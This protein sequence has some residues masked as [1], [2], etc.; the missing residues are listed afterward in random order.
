MHSGNSGVR[1]GSGTTKVRFSAPLS[2]A[3]DGEEA[4]PDEVGPAGYVGIAGDHP[5]QP[6]RKST[7]SHH[8]GD[9]SLQPV[10][11]F[12]G[13]TENFVDNLRPPVHDRDYVFEVA[14][15]QIVAATAAPE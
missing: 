12:S 15:G 8:G 3:G 11:E 1:A 4:L 6:I 9:F 2:P 10:P 7:F 5:P 14:A 13:R